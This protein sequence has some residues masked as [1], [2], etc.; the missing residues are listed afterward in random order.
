MSIVTV[1]QKCAHWVPCAM[2]HLEEPADT[3]VEEFRLTQWVLAL[4]ADT[5][6][7]TELMIVRGMAPV[8]RVGGCARLLEPPEFT[9]NG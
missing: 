3:P 4:V 6:H 7:A 2:M 8:F 9:E 1:H 5:T